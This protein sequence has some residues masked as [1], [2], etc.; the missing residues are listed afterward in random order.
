MESK[1][2]SLQEANVQKDKRILDLNLQLHQTKEAISLHVAAAASLTTQLTTAQGEL[3]EEREALAK[4]RRDRAA[5]DKKYRVR[6]LCVCLWLCWAVGICPCAPQ[7][8]KA[9]I[10]RGN[11]SREEELHREVEAVQ[12]VCP[13]LRIA[14][15]HHTPLGCI[16]CRTWLRRR[17]R[18]Q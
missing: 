12:K 2:V 7:E 8:L 4:E 3:T 9:I 1:L 13:S 11:D 5:L 15:L 10:D 18:L 17:M 16:V 6:W 14:I